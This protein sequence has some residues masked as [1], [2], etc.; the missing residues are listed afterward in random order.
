MGLYRGPEE[1][2]CPAQLMGSG[3]RPNNCDHWVCH[4]SRVDARDRP[5]AFFVQKVHTR[6]LEFQVEYRFE[7]PQTMVDKCK[8]LLLQAELVL[9]KI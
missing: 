7:Q 2:A 8:K 9:G 4:F 1:K 5:S 3:L 6:T